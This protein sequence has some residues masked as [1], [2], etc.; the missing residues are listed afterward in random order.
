MSDTTT[1]DEHWQDDNKGIQR[2]LRVMKAEG[3]RT[4]TWKAHMG[5]CGPC[6]VNDGQTVTT[7]QRFASGAYL[8]PD[9]NHCI[10]TWVDAQGHQYEWT[11]DDGVYK[12]VKKQ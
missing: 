5:A 10:C 4:V 6:T 7:G 12:Q 2:K 8:P 1:P 3:Q 9:H 11:G